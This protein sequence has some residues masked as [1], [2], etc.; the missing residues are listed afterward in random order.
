MG[1]N[2]GR[3]DDDNEVTGLTDA[4]LVERHR[5]LSSLWQER[6]DANRLAEEEFLARPAPETLAGVWA[7]RQIISVPDPKIGGLEREM[8]RRLGVMFKAA[9]L[10]RGLTIRD[11]AR[12]ARHNYLAAIAE[13]ERGQQWVDRDF[14]ERVCTEGGLSP[15]DANLRRS[16][17]FPLLDDPRCRTIRAVAIDPDWRTWNGAVIELARSI[18][19]ERSFQL[20]PI[21]GDALEAAGCADPDLL[22]HCRAPGVHVLGCWVTDALVGARR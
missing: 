9:R 5:L 14:Y 1:R 10:A 19:R 16:D 21:L 12:E 15:T 18:A 11:V 4:E 8:N 2:A 6:G 20:L 22:A 7:T 3:I 13:I 17:W